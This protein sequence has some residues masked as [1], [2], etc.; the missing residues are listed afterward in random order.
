MR[1]VK[2]QTFDYKRFLIHCSHLQ[3]AELHSDPDTSFMAPTEYPT[4][5][6]APHT[7]FPPHIRYTPFVR[8]SPILCALLALQGPT[9]AP[10]PSSVSELCEAV[11][12]LTHEPHTRRI[13]RHL[14]KFIT[15]QTPV[16]T[17]RGPTPPTHRFDSPL[18]HS[19]TPTARSIH[20]SRTPRPRSPNYSLASGQ[21]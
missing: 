19:R 11:P 17:R 6:A 15:Q 16:Y 1:R 10:R 7:T 9:L 18:F 5:N 14:L 8:L 21:P 20:H 13:R 3:P 2:S 12:P 4:D